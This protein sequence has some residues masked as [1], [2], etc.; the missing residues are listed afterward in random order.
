MIRVIAVLLAMLIVIWAGGREARVA[1]ATAFALLLP[2]GFRCNSSGSFA[3]LATIR[4]GQ[5]LAS[6]LLSNRFY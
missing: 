4:P 2:I 6:F 1:W 3:T 5:T